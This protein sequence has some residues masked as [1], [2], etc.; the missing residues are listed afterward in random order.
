MSAPTNDIYCEIRSF[1]E[2]DIDLWLAEELKVNAP[3]SLW[4]ANHSNPTSK[5]RV[6][7]HKLK[8]LS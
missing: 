1:V 6:P 8:Y 7:A 4:F 3:F 5:I 2:R